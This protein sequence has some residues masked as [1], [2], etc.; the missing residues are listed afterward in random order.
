MTAEDETK[1]KAEVLFGGR[2]LVAYQPEKQ[3]IEKVPEP[4]K[5]AKDP[6][7]S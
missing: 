5:A 7:R 2:T 4:A 1:L 3:E 6:R